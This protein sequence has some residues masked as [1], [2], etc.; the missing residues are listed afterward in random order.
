[1]KKQIIALLLLTLPMAAKAATLEPLFGYVT[2]PKGI[3]VKVVQ[4]GPINTEMN[5]DNSDFATALKS[6]TALGGYGN[7][8]EV[9][10][11]VAFLASPEASYIT[12]AALDVGGG[13]GA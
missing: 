10:V 2:G 4:P 3:T 1:M 13:L 7:P 11:A 5:P 12:G 6:A 9:A 8:G